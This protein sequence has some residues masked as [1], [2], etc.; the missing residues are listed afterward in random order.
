MTRNRRCSVQDDGV[1]TLRQRALN[2]THLFAQI[3]DVESTQIDNGLSADIECLHTAA[4]Y[5][6]ALIGGD[7]SGTGNQML[8]AA[9]CQKRTI[10]VL[11]SLEWRKNSAY[12][13]RDAANLPV[14][15]GAFR[16][17]VDK[18]DH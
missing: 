3:L 15:D 18:A 8:L 10:D 17:Q 11:T 14:G 4:A 13:Y 5:N 6:L 9:E 1:S 12:L 7:G 16:L 2:P